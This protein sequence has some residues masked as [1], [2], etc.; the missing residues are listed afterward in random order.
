MDFVRLPP[1]EVH[2]K[3]IAGAKDT[4]CVI[5]IELKR[6]WWIV[7]WFLIADWAHTPLVA[8]C[9][10]NAGVGEAVE[11]LLCLGVTS[12]NKIYWG[13]VFSR[14]K[15]LMLAYSIVLI[16]WADCR[17]HWKSFIARVH[18]RVYR[19]ELR[20]AVVWRKVLRHRLV[21]MALSLQLAEP[22]DDLTLR[23]I[24]WYELVCILCAGVL[25]P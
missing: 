4:H 21:A 17:C 8:L 2:L 1:L 11:L 16:F 10:Q 6:C 19:V 22:A 25:V 5:A 18:I 13:A 15:W 20:T 12:V 24:D 3:V 9:Q 14:N 7:D 23:W